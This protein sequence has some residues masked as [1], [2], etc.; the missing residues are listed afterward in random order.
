MPDIDFKEL[1]NLSP[2]VALLIFLYVIGGVLK[3]AAFFPDRFLPITQ[4][5]LG[6][7]IYPVLSSAVP[8]GYYHPLA[9]QIFWGAL[10]GGGTVAA[11][12]SIKQFLAKR[13][14]TLPGDTDITTKSDK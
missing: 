2:P 8:V 7:A 9:T 4:V 12:Q 1:A 3:K 6:A 11:N 5:L 14:I 13:G 10:I